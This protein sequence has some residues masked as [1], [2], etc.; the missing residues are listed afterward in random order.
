MSA[1]I[2]VSGGFGV[3][4]TTF[5]GSISEIEP[6]RTEERMTAAAAIH[7]DAS[8]V[9]TK[10]STTVAMDFGR[11]TIDEAL[12]VYVFGTPGQDRFA[13][14]WDR[15]SEGALGA[16]VLVDTARLDDCYASIDYFESRRIPFVVAVNHFL[17]AP[18][19]SATELRAVLA[20]DESVPI[21][22][23]DARK[24]PAVKATL[25][26]LIDHL[27]ST[28]ST[29]GARRPDASFGLAAAH[30][31]IADDG[32]ECSTDV[33]AVAGVGVQ[34]RYGRRHL[35]RGPD[36][37]ELVGPIAVER[38]HGHDERHVA[39][40]EV[41]DRGEAVGESAGV[42]EHDR[43]DRPAD[44]LVPHEPVARLAGR[45]EQVEHEFVAQRDA[46]E[47]HRD[48]RG[49]LGAGE[50]DVVDLVAG[51]GDERF[52]LERLDLG[53]GVDERR[54]ADAEP[55]GHHDLDGDD[56]DRRP[57]LACLAASRRCPRRRSN[58]R[59]GRDHRAPSRA[60]WRTR[61]RSPVVGGP[62]VRAP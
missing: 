44:Q 54:L 42:R 61:F 53:D 33:V 20:L 34:H 28:A 31:R 39:L 9:R 10:H 41:V 40:F 17:N 12:K 59:V 56:L 4:K 29:T 47:V 11:I 57:C 15:I 19:G 21:L 55:A 3:G 14:M 26:A 2:V 52:G 36:V 8:K 1:K 37:V 46:S 6:L 16:V 22:S 43:A 30:Q 38:V 13:F 50:R 5:V 62:V 18:E 25:L 23:V 35:E 27:L 45:A 60:G 48:R 51:L 7:D 58:V 49:R 32:L 24:R